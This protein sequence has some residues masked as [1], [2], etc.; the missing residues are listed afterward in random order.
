MGGRRRLCLIFTKV[1][2]GLPR[3]RILIDWKLSLRHIQLSFKL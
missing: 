3:S 1:S 2:E